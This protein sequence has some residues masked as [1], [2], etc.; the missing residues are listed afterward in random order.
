MKC[1]HTEIA[2]QLGVNKSTISRELRRNRGKRGY[3]PKQAHEKA[4]GR[5]ARKVHT[6]INLETWQL[7]EEK[8]Q[9][10]WSPEQIS[11]WLNRQKLPSVSPEWIYQYIYTDK[12]VGGNLHKHLR[13]HT[14]PG[15]RC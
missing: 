3:R 12:K 8:L 6:R 7:V 1:T 14:C 13:C 5:C 10:D 15:G 4:K 2:Q 11:S 9:M